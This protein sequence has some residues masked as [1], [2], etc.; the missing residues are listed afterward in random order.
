MALDE[1]ARNWL[2]THIR[3]TVKFDE[4]MSKHTSFKVGGPAEAYVQPESMEALMMLI[5][6]SLENRIPFM[7]I[8]AGTNLLVTDK[9]IPGIVIV[10]NKCLGKIKQAGEQNDFVWV[11]A[12][13]GAKLQALCRYGV[14]QGLAGLNFALGI[15]GTVG[16]GVR[17]NA[18]TALGCMSDVLTAVTV[19]QPG[20]ELKRLGK[21]TLNFS[22]RNLWFDDVNNGKSPIILDGCFRL[23][24]TASDALHQEAKKIL[25]SRNKREPI[26]YPSAGCF[27]KN[28]SPENPAGRLI[29]QAGLKGRQIGGAQVAQKHANYIVN[30]GNASADDIFSLMS[31]IQETV[32]HQ[33]NI[34]LVPEVKI[35]GKR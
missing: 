20:G 33:F 8:G 21:E 32:R 13:A 23:R 31:L 14:T 1:R 24:K 9:G 16:G 2:S 11:N 30:S 22:Y 10:L 5:D 7:V 6:W 34:N 27:F 29:E 28:P 4:P 19:L 15:P 26:E 35:V 18:G 12:M 17:M 3:G 25:E